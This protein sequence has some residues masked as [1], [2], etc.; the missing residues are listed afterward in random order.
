MAQQ[1][2][3]LRYPTVN[4]HQSMFLYDQ[5]TGSASRGN[6]NYNFRSVRYDD[7]ERA[8]D[9]KQL[10]AGSPGSSAPAGYYSA[11]NYTQQRGRG[12]QSYNLYKP[13]PSIQPQI[14]AYKRQQEESQA[15]LKAQYERQLKVLQIE[16][17]KLKEQEDPVIELPETPDYASIIA[18]SNQ[19]LSQRFDKMMVGNQ[20]SA[21]ARAD[22][23]QSSLQQMREAQ[24]SSQSAFQLQS[25]NQSAEFQRQSAKQSAAF[26]SQT[27]AQAAYQRQAAE[28]QAEYFRQS[29]TQA[30][31]AA[32][33][34]AAQ[35][36]A[37]SQAQAQYFRQ[38]FAQAQAAQDQS[39]AQAQ[40]AA[41]A[42][43]KAQG[44]I[45]SSIQSASDKAQE[46]AQAQSA[47]QSA[48]YS[49][50]EEERK[51]LQIS[52]RTSRAN[53]ARS[54]LQAKYRLGGESGMKRGGTFGFRRRNRPTM[55]GITS[56]TASSAGSLN[57]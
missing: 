24:A 38:S 42:Q 52:Q 35:A 55:G 17:T 56:N 54:N 34:Q 48:Y 26:Q 25:A 37:A 19:E 10:I 30:Q 5:P 15:E 6:A 11:G 4:F 27:A 33:A 8:L 7:L 18:K 40:A 47:A 45:L 36:Q 20:Q 50:A 23:Y 1:H 12:S 29:S 32:K 3:D 51:Q 49:K 41:Q 14:D 16:N 2:R 39:A 28:A 43:T 46:S 22:Q 21:A 57:V 31:S 13:F 44:D 9:A 53:Q